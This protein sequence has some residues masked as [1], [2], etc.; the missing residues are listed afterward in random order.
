MQKYP[1]IKVVHEGFTGED[2]YTKI[3]VL[4]AGGSAGGR[5]VDGHR[6]GRHL[7]P[8][9]GE[10]AP[11]RRALRGQ[12]EVRP[13]P[14]LQERASRASSATASSTACPS[15]ATPASRSCSTTR[16]PTR[17]SG[18]RAGQDLDPGPPGGRRQARHPGA[19][20]SA[21][22]RT[23]VAEDPSSPPPAPSAASCSTR[24]A[25]SPC[26][27]RP[28][29]CRPITWLYETIN[30]HNIAPQ[31]VGGHRAGRAW[32]GCSPTASCRPGKWGTS[33]Q[34]VAQPGRQGLLQVVRHRSTRRGRRGVAGLGL[35]GRTPTP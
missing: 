34:I 5:D 30:R 27:T 1:N 28:R 18:G 29:R 12:G 11:A 35:R 22:T 19:T 4:S 26:S 32:T 24:R 14:V 3:T 31:A 21:T 15:R 23:F 6:R 7:L 33:F 9:R 13:H 10:G 25:R 8:R 2:Y 17:R 16:P 20:S